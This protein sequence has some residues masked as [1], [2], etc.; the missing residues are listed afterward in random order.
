MFI[1]KHTTGL[2]LISAKQKTAPNT[3]AQFGNVLSM[4]VCGAMLTA[5]FFPAAAIG[6]DSRFQKLFSG[7][8]SSI[9]KNTAA[10]E[11]I[12]QNELNAE[13]AEIYKKI[14]ALQKQKKWS[15]A[16]TL[17][18]QLKDKR[19]LGHV[20][21]ARYLDNKYKPSSTEMAFWLFNYNNQP[22]AAAVYKKFAQNYPKL[23]NKVDNYLRKNNAHNIFSVSANLQAQN[24][25]E[26]SR[27][28]FS[29]N[30]FAKSYQFAQNAIEASEGKLNEAY[31]R[32]GLSAWAINKKE[33][34]ALSFA[35][36]AE[37][38][39]NNAEDTAKASF[40]AWRAYNDIGNNA[41]ADKFINIAANY[42]QSFYGKMAQAISD[43]D[44][45]SNQ[46]TSDNS[47]NIKNIPAQASLLPALSASGQTKLARKV[48]THLMRTSPIKERLALLEVAESLEISTLP[49]KKKH[50][51]KISHGK[52]TLPNWVARLKSGNLRPLVLAITR[53][54]S[55][56]NPNAGSEQGAQG[57]MQIMP[58]TAELM[59]NKYG[60]LNIATASIDKNHGFSALGD[61]EQNLKN[62]VYNLAVGQAYLQHLG[63]DRNVRNNIIMLSSSY[64]AGSN[65]ALRWRA[66]Y[67]PKDP[68]LFIESIPFAVTRE[69][70]KDVLRDYWVYAKMLNENIDGPEKLAKGKWPHLKG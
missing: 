28:A 3:R 57:L 9:S 11:F 17:S 62:P 18:L 45:N 7:T 61:I 47:I 63:R 29:D 31:W 40:W 66:H 35:W 49:A 41:Q 12:A 16:N 48:L 58:Q 5:I 54:E 1:N 46:Q 23:N 26:K 33:E 14:F 43:D 21:A 42:P 55:N 30:D 19:L 70:V 50:K 13:D 27:N 36:M 69:Y 15:A 59:V 56:F 4:M 38:G 67:R 25:L 64:N 2:E 68:L 8:F 65:I 20:L 39:T 6:S 60:A 51:G 44:N 32:A 24:L 37:N 10:E 34:A 22:E 53:N 52:Y